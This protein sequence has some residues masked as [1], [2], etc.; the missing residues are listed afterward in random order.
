MVSWGPAT[1]IG[2][3]QAMS[4]RVSA[5][6]ELAGS[7]VW[8]GGEAGKDRAAHLLVVQVGEVDAIDFHNLVSCLGGVEGEDDSVLCE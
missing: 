3:V 7:S 4:I 6:V 2:A 1:Q 8:G 5:V